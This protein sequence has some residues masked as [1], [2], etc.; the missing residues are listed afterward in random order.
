MTTQNSATEVFAVV[1]HRVCQKRCCPAEPVDLS[2]GADDGRIV[3]RESRYTKREP[4]STGEIRIATPAKQEP[5]RT[6]DQA[7]SVD[8]VV[9]EARETL[10]PKFARNTGTAAPCCTTVS[11]P[12]HGRPKKQT[13]IF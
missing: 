2:A 3:F 5:F 4:V 7:D 12:L 8:Q 10:S 1:P 11:V 13:L 9:A 6:V